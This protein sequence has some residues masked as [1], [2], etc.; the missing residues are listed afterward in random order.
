VRLA[1][2]VAREWIERGTAEQVQVAQEILLLLTG[3]VH[4]D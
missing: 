2:D 1:A 4:T 3:E